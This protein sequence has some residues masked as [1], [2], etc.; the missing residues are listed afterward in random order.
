MGSV[1]QKRIEVVDMSSIE[2]RNR[3]IGNKKFKGVEKEGEQTCTRCMKSKLLNDYS[4][5]NCLDGK[6]SLCKKCDNIRSKNNYAKSVGK[7]RDQILDYNSIEYK[8][9]NGKKMCAECEQWK[10]ENDFTT[11]CMRKDSKNVYC[12][13]C[14][15]MRIY[16][17]NVR[18]TRR[19]K[20]KCMLGYGGRCNCCGDSRVE[21]LTLEH[22][23]G[24]GIRCQ[25]TSLMRKLIELKFPVGYLCLC[26]GCNVATKHGRP[27]I[28]S[29]EWLVYY[30][31]YI[32]SYQ[33]SRQKEL[34][35]LERQWAVINR[36]EGNE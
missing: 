21:M 15:S 4:V 11:D 30:N 34:D 13:K 29:K 33:Y 1:L 35:G 27:C 25:T 16:A 8:I 17:Y 23:N 6:S 10:S 9:V 2:F 14:R 12:N 7:N 19:V 20:L 3:G 28:H 31:K 5:G 22:V 26:Y 24:K 18:E 36:K 32:K